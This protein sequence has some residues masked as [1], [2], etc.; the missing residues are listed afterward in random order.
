M[1]EEGCKMGGYLHVVIVCQKKV[2]RLD[3]TVN[4]FVKVHLT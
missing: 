3:I 4:H 1:K 2:L